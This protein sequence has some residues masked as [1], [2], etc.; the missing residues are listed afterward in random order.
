MTILGFGGE[1]PSSSLLPAC[2]QYVTILGPDPSPEVHQ[3]GS[4][5][6]VAG[7]AQ[8]ART[9]FGLAV[10]TG[11]PVWK[12]APGSLGTPMK[13]A[14]AALNYYEK[15]GDRF[16]QYVD[17]GFSIAVVDFAARRVLLAIDR[18][19]IER[20]AYTVQG[21]VLGFG[22]SAEQLAR[23]PICNLRISA[24]AL[25]DFLLAH[26]IAAPETIFSGVK[27][28]RPA[29]YA[30]FENQR[31]TVNHYWRPEFNESMD[32]ASVA[33]WEQDL[34]AGLRSAV[35]ACSPDAHTGAFLSGGL[36]SS[37]VAGFLAATSAGRARTFSMGFGV[38]AYDEL[39]Y[40]RIAA[41][42]FHCDSTEYVVT[43]DDVVTAFP[44]IARAYDEPFG[45]SSAVPTYMCA[46][47]A[48]EQGITHMLA[49]DG[50]DEIFG[51][52]ERYVRQGTFEAYQRIPGPLRSFLIEP[53]SRL[54]AP[55]SGLDLLR[56]A[57][58]Y[59]SQARIP[60]PERLEAWNFMYRT[61]AAEILDGDFARSI[62][63]RAPFR[64]M[65][66]VY[67]AAPADSLLNKMM[68]YDWQFTLA[69]ND[70]RKVGL[71]CEL[72]KVRVS[73]P[74]LD[75][76]VVD[77]SMRVPSSVK[78]RGQELRSFY[79]RAMRDFLPQPIL[80]KSKHG[81]GLPFGQWLKTHSPL[82]D[83]FHS[84][85][86]NFKKRGIVRPD[87]IDN[88]IASHEGGH[89]SYFGYAIWDVAMLEAWLSEHDKPVTAVV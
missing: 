66:E 82:R 53:L 60:M 45:N 57:R 64:N 88:L 24:Q 15:F 19:G 48:A 26:M 2:R 17:G 39:R 74:M 52:N 46:L 76:R 13:G 31:L 69:D 84:T 38:E 32:S 63:V 89:A 87:F 20:M 28:L 22:T 36:D 55:D 68:Y 77:L 34:H 80:Q 61:P 51:G 85:L 21:G 78:I 9:P 41:R 49:G 83:L 73:Y 67:D 35:E 4:W 65:Q 12:G 3:A 62:D 37:T 54:I 6:A 7:G 70:L 81:F 50:G 44:L 14:A 71:M 47:R 10:V 1:L 18:M 40:A 30:V 16:L 8:V 25:Y 59:V 56:K 86:Q 79:K 75:R 29:S 43:P 42:H 58:S 11:S 72:A 27:K 23:S 5:G 33:Q